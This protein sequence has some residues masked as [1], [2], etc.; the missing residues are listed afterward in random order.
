MVNLNELA[1]ADLLAVAVLHGEYERIQA[2]GE[3]GRVPHLMHQ[4][5]PARIIASALG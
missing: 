3:R 5:P 2:V 4:I 1:S